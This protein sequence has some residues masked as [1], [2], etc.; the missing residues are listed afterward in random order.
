MG[1]LDWH[2]F[3]LQTTGLLL[4]VADCAAQTD[5]DCEAKCVL[6]V[7]TFMDWI[8]QLY[9]VVLHLNAG[10]VSLGE[11]L[12]ACCWLVLVAWFLWGTLGPKLQ[13]FEGMVRPERDEGVF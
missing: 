12:L 5:A 13:A 1:D 4:W 2:G 11:F 7:Q 3:L 6:K 10:G 8:T 9:K